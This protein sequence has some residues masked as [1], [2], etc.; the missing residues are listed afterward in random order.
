MFKAF[1]YKN[2]SFVNF[3]VNEL[4]KKAADKNQLSHKLSTIKLLASYDITLFKKITTKNIEEFNNWLL[5]NGYKQRY[6]DYVHTQIKYCVKQAIKQKLLSKNPYQMAVLKKGKI[7]EEKKHL[8]NYE[9]ENIKNTVFA[10]N[11]VQYAADIFLF[12]AYT[13]LAYA[14]IFKLEKSMIIEQN[15]K[16]WIISNRVKTGSKY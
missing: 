6:I 15:G 5:S 11:S 9:L 8:E 14:D 10:S 7:T 2:K 13:G 4:T 16:N 1:F 3:C 12:S